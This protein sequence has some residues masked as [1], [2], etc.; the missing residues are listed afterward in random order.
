MPTIIEIPRFR[1]NGSVC[2]SEF[3]PKGARPGEY[4]LTYS[5][6]GQSRAIVGCYSEMLTV[7]NDLP[8]AVGFIVDTRY[9]C[10]LYGNPTKTFT[11]DPWDRADIQKANDNAAPIIITKNVSSSGSNGESPSPTTSDVEF[12][13]QDY[14]NEMQGF[15]VRKTG[16][17]L[18]QIRL[19]DSKPEWTVVESGPG[20]LFKYAKVYR[21]P[22]KPEM[23]AKNPAVFGY[24]IVTSLGDEYFPIFF[25]QEVT[26]D[27]IQF[28]F[29]LMGPADGPKPEP[30]TLVVNIS[31]VFNDY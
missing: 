31:G 24:N 7:N 19:M 18:W 17:R 14:D 3:I 9:D 2:T 12:L 29:T 30:T 28:L 11:L 26:E 16:A 1:A 8:F 15:N 20:E 13:I 25:T 10:L 23:N 5:M 27:Q 4:E 22:F 6:R 21:I